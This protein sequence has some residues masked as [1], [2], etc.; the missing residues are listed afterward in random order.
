MKIGVHLIKG[1]SENIEYKITN[2][3]IDKTKDRITL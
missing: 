2:K 1:E 3:I